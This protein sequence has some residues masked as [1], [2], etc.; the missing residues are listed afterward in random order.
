MIAKRLF[1]ERVELSCRNITLKL[2]IPCSP[3]KLQKPGAKLPELFRRKRLNLL[4]D[5]FDLAHDS[6]LREQR[7]FNTGYR[8]PANTGIQP[9]NRRESQFLR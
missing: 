7:Q 1:R 5:I 4:L 8:L 9:S 2:S 3:I 6:H